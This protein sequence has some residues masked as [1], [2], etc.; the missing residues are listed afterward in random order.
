MAEQASGE[1]REQASKLIREACGA[2]GIPSGYVLI[3]KEE[4]GVATIVTKGGKR[5][6][7][8]EGQKVERR[9]TPGECGVPLPRKK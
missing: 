5:V 6:R 2:Y 3:A 9:L 7:Y 1:S 8:T 4:G